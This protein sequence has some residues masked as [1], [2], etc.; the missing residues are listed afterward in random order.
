MSNDRTT[1]FQELINE[2]QYMAEDF[3]YIKD[4]LDLVTTMLKK[5]KSADYILDYIECALE[6]LEAD[7]DE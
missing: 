3:N 4:C 2:C 7:R 6:E 5:G 1:K